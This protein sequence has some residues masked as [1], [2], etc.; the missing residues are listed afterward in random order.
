MDKFLSNSEGI[1][2]PLKG[3]LDIVLAL[4]ALTLAAPVLLL[5]A[6][7]VWLQDFHSPFYLSRRIAQFGGSFTMIKIRSM[8]VRAESVGVNST[9]TD[10]A[11]ITRVGRLIRKFK[12]DELSQF[13]NVLLGDMSVV[14]PRPNTWA[15]GVELY[16][17]TETT[18]LAVRPGITDLSSIV[19]SD[20]GD[21]LNGAAHPDLMYNQIIRPWKS[22]L[23]LWYVANM[24]LSLD[25]RI[26]WLTVLAILDKPRAISGV[27]KL[28]ERGDA[29]PDLIAVCRRDHNLPAAPPPGG[30]KIEDGAFYA[31]K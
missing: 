6:L 29:D 11:R 19:F 15:W 22:R 21:I 3:S 10:D 27:V 18:I 2:Y 14:G 13:I 28:L 17:R 4:V 9:G 7:L 5:S 16:T 30:E 26:C 1:T 12:I 23:A 25:I 20:E 8:V 24:S 31:T